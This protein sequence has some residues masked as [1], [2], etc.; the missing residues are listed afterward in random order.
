MK[1]EAQLPSLDE[2]APAEVVVQNDITEDYFQAGN[3]DG[4][5]IGITVD[6]IQM[7]APV[8][9]INDDGEGHIYVRMCKSKH[10]GIHCMFLVFYALDVAI[11]SLLLL[12]FFSCLAVRN[13]FCT[14]RVHM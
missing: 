2:N 1:K 9:S 7:D 14:S 6:S 3:T 11:V 10:A 13:V 5:D 12:A 4:D 8:V